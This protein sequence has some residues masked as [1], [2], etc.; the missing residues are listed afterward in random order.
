MSGLIDQAVIDSNETLPP[1]WSITLRV[2]RRFAYRSR[3]TII[4]N[5]GG[6]P[7]LSWPGVYDVRRA[8]PVVVESIRH[9]AAGHD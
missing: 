6:I 9:R 8:L 7:L 4:A 3:Y 2:E 1:G 5:R